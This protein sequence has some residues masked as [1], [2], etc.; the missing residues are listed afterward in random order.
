M[1][2]MTQ[3]FLEHRFVKIKEVN[4]EKGI[5]HVT[6]EYNSDLMISLHVHDAVF[7]VPVVGE[8]W[9]V[10]RQ[11]SDWLLEKKMETG[12]DA[13]LLSD[14]NQG[15]TRISGQAVHLPLVYLQGGGA[16]FGENGSLKYQD[17]NGTVT[18]LVK[19]TWSQSW[20]VRIRGA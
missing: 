3:R 6:D 16:L 2:R 1:D 9:L 11:N 8:T 15:E 12:N 14:M 20:S 10:S 17:P 13:L 7:T 5:I 4:M 19:A 18:T